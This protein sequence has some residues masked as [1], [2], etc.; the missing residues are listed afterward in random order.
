MHC[1]F[2]PQLKQHIDSEDLGLVHFDIFTQVKHMRR[3]YLLRHLQI[4]KKFNVTLTSETLDTHT[5]W[6]KDDA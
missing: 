5:F 6:R 1:F 2:I 3:S 4:H